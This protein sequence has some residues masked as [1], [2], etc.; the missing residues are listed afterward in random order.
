MKR[1][2]NRAW[3]EAVRR[4]PCLICGAKSEAHHLQHAEPSAMGLKSGDQYA[5]PLC[6][7][8]HMQ[9][10]AMGNER[11]WWA[12]EGVDPLD[13]LAGQHGERFP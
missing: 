5:V 10:H 1:L 8:H 9:L 3:L 7:D 11:R 6:H 2:R 12:I 4:M 13:W